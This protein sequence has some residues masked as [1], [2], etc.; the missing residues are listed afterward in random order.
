MESGDRK[1]P[2]CLMWTNNHQV[3]ETG[4]PSD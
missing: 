2:V 3:K 1:E 4:S